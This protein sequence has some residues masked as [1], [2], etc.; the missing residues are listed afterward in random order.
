MNGTCCYRQE[1]EVGN[2]QDTED[3]LASV[4]I[5]SYI[6]SSKTYVLVFASLWAV[7]LCCDFVTWLLFQLHC[8]KQTAE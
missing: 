8:F 2:V 3:Y 5:C 6:S 1:R 7:V 4:H